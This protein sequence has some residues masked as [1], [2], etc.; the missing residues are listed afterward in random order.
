MAMRLKEG[1]RLSAQTRAKI[2]EAIGNGEKALAIL[3]SLLADDQEVEAAEVLR[4]WIQDDDR[5]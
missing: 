4:F 3:R 5:F 2:E 1:R